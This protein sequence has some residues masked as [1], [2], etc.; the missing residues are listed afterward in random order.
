[1]TGFETS[2][3]YEAQ[4]SKDIS[5]L[6]EQQIQSYRDFCDRLKDTE[7]LVYRVE[8][9][10]WIDID[11]QMS[12]LFQV[13]GNEW[14]F[15]A[16]LYGILGDMETNYAVRLQDEMWSEAQ[17]VRNNSNELR[18]YVQSEINTFISQWSMSDQQYASFLNNYMNGRFGNYNM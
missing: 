13:I 7:A 1:M 6:T 3:Q 8:S 10:Y 4:C 12:D 15:K 16:T 14:D 18:A 9:Q 11:K 17:V 5:E 2:A